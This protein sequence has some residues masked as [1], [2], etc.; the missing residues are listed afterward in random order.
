MPFQQNAA[1]A[2]VIDPI[3]SA[4]ARAAAMQSPLVA[5]V[6]FP[7]V[8]VAQRGGRI[9]TFSTDDFRIYNTGRAPGANTKRVGFGYGSE[10]FALVDYSLEGSVPIE[11]LEEGLAVPGLNHADMAIAK[12]RNLQGLEREKQCAD[13]ATNAALY[14]AENK[15]TLSAGTQW[16][17]A[18]STPINAVATAREAVRA[19]IGVRPNTMVVGPK[20]ATALSINP[21]ILARLRGGTGADQR[22]K[23]PASLDEIAQVLGVE[24]VIEGGS[25]WHSGTAF[26]DVWGTFAM[27]AYTTP[28]SMQ[29][30]GSPSFGYTYQ[31]QG[32]PVAEEPY[33]DRNTKTWYFPVTD[34]RQPVLTGADAGFLWT[35]AAA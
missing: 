29:E 7:T 12:V 33:Y 24:R 34:A 2:R 31:L 9:I 4:V 6:L 14:A 17:H 22:N 10:A 15:A 1:Q 16:S 30:M 19:K 8:P 5:D 20:V 21:Q 32:Y 23:A 13:L 25:I 26:A 35:A 11:T 3:L 28:R 18:D 27:L